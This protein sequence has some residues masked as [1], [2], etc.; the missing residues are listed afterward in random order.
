ML[1][2]ILGLV[3]SEPQ[4]MTPM[5]YQVRFM[6]IIGILVIFGLWNRLKWNRIRVWC[7]TKG[8]N[9]SESN[10]PYKLSVKTL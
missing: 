2:F 6:V 3:Y 9:T 1:H 10:P 8:E 7:S 4:M 5:I